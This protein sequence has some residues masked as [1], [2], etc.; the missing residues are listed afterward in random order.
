MQRQSQIHISTNTQITQKQSIAVHSCKYLMNK[1]IPWHLGPAE[2]RA[3]SKEVAKRDA[4][5]G[6]LQPEWSKGTVYREQ[7][8]EL[9]IRGLLLVSFD[10]AIRK[11]YS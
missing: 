8:L 6:A 10:I 5:A 4:V 7:I 11:D 3:S 2:A 9:S 1:M